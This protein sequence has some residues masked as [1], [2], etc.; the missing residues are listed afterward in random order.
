MIYFVPKNL[1]IFKIINFINSIYNIVSNFSAG[2]TKD[3][4]VIFDNLSKQMSNQVKWTE[5]IKLLEN[6]NEKNTI[7]KKLKTLSVAAG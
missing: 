4:N 1:N 7:S 3:K 6:F 2:A 5:S